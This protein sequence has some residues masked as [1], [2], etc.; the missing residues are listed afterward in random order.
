MGKAT[1]A[2]NTWAN[3]T[4][5]VFYQSEIGAIG[6]NKLKWYILSVDENGVNLVSEPTR[7]KVQFKD[8]A[9]YDNCLYYLNELST[10]LFENE[11]YGITSDRIHTLRL[12]DI[13]KAAEQFNKEY[14]IIDNEVERDWNW[15]YD[16]IRS[17]P[18]LN[19]GFYTYN[20]GIIG[21]KQIEGINDKYY[22]E[23]YKSDINKEV[24]ANNELY[25]E[26]PST[27]VK[28]NGIKRELEDGS[29][30]ASKLTVNLT[31]ICYNSA[32]DLMIEKLGNFGQSNI[33]QEIF[34]ENKGC[35]L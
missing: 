3:G 2:S 17:A 18:F 34:G 11:E 22:P 35:S 32:K 31:Y 6:D 10:K 1:Y 19:N 20:D 5:Q 4:N 21:K 26:E 8:S 13:K 30:P 12:T 14:K 24:M 16:F 28:D 23:L 33:A 29:N 25:D 7:K 27:L 9:G 15:N